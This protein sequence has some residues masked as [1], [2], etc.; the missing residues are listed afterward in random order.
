MPT[1]AFVPVPLTD[2]QPRVYK[3]FRG[4][5]LKGLLMAVAGV[6]VSLSNLGAKDFAGYA[7]AFFL[8][9]PGFAYGYYYPQGK[10]V[11]YWLRVLYRYYTAP[12]VL[13][14]QRQAT[15]PRWRIFLAQF[16]PV[17]TAALTLIR[18]RWQRRKEKRTDG[19]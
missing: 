2:A 14:S 10:P 12:Q 5:Q 9:L 16:D 18:Q 13:T 1:R 4:R 6:A 11:E 15:W 17:F 8:A 3:S 7:L 19:R